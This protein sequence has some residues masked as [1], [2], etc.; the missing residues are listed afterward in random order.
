MTRNKIWPRITLAF[1]VIN[2]L[3]G[4][5]L[6]VAYAMAAVV[7]RVGEADQSLRFWYLPILFIGI[8]A[9]GIGLSCTF[10]AF[11]RLRNI[12]RAAAGKE[13]QDLSKP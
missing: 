12:R 6:V 11:N 13:S 2:S 10:W 4:G 5:V 3:A 1:G 8:M 9:L 7:A